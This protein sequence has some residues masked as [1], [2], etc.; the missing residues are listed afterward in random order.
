M[1][2]SG[3]QG[4]EGV[5]ITLLPEGTAARNYTV[6]FHFAEPDDLKPGER[7]FDVTVQ[8]RRVLDDL[9]IVKEAGRPR[10]AV[11]RELHGV[12]VNGELRISFQSSTKRPAVLCGIEVIED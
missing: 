1:A 3:V 2:A 6:R 10:T 5:A 8:G 11:V 12:R 4:V 9:D 7:V